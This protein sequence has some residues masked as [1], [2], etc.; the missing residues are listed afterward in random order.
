MEKNYKYIFFGTPE[1]SAEVLEEMKRNDFL[2]SLIVTAP[3]KPKGRKLV[4]TPPEAKV[5]A[6]DNDIPFLQPPTLRDDVV[7]NALK[8]VAWDFFVLASY[9][10]ILPKEILD[11]PEHGVLNIHPSLLPKL[12]GASPVHTAI[13]RENETGVSIMLMDEKM[14]H[15]PVLAQEKFSGVDFPLPEPEL[16]T[17]LAK[18]GARLLCETIPGFIKGEIEIHPQNEEE[19]SYTKK[20]QKEDALLDLNSPQKAEENYRK[21]LAYERWPK[22]Y[23]FTEKNGRE[24]RIIVKKARLEDGVLI[25]ERVLP[26]GRKEMSYKEYQKWLT[27]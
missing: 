5:W 25:L 16:E 22:A 3:D 21:I 2:P 14:D 26:E 6:L 20:I 18:D 27:P 9:G 7:Q 24:I 8:E 13:L 11:I 10:K 23:F 15:G 1:F 19:A 4:L 12:R 17:I